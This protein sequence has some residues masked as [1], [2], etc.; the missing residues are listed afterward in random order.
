MN[1]A[2]RCGCGEY[3]Y[4]CE[5]HKLKKDTTMTNYKDL[6]IDT[7]KSNR[8]LCETLMCTKKGWNILHYNS[9]IFQNFC[10]NAEVLDNYGGENC[11]STYYSVIRFDLKEGGSVTFKFDGWYAS[12]NGADFEKFF[13][14][15]GEL[16][17]KIDWKRGSSN[18]EPGSYEDYQA[19]SY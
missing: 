6:L 11:G 13:E 2:P 14:V 10:D 5:C 17:T 3:T 18:Y 7:L 12:Y 1:N 4:N 8:Q 9:N 15:Y 19:G 16:V